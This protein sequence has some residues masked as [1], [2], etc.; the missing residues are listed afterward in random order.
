M[1]SKGRRVRAFVNG[2]GQGPAFLASRKPCY[3]GELFTVTQANGTVDRWT[4]YDQSL[5]VAGHTALCA[6]DGA[7]LVTRNRFG[8]KKTVA[9]PELELKLGCSYALLGNLEAQI[10]NGLFDGACVE[11][12]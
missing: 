12:A 2:N 8:V 3:I 9:V 4:S 7:P 10:H 5:T 6:R 11:M 1:T